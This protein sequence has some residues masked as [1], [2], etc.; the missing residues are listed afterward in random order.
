[1]EK[2]IS[3]FLFISI[4]KIG[5]AQT[6]LD[7][8]PMNLYNNYEID[9]RK[10][11]KQQLLSPNSDITLVGDSI[12][13]VED[14]YNYNIV[15]LDSIN[16]N[17]IYTPD[18][19]ELNFKNIRAIRLPNKYIQLLVGNEVKSL[20][21]NQ[22]VDGEI[23]TVVTGGCGNTISFINFI[24]RDSINNF[25]LKKHIDNSRRQLK[26][27]YKR[28]KL[29]AGN[30][31]DSLYFDNGNQI[32]HYDDFSLYKTRTNTIY[33]KKKTGKYNIATYQ[34]NDKDNIFTLTEKL[35]DDVDSLQMKHPIYFYKENKIGYYPTMT[36]AKY[37]SLDIEGEF[38]RYKK[39][40]GEMGWLDSINGKEY[41]DL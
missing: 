26:N 11:G 5:T 3:L 41:P 4:F 13:I 15:V 38:L 10:D 24:Q 9:K 14:Y 19:K 17:K 1:M 6:W 30:S 33:I 35:T 40:N 25:F 36:Q 2:F 20:Y 22:L 27:E 16:G 28:Y 29:I 31:I 12:F 8:E 34:T 32:L 37:K 18:F 21:Q 7:D 39:E 23:I